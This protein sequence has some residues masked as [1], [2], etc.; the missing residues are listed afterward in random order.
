[1]ANPSQKSGKT[2]R[3]GL[4]NLLI[5]LYRHNTDKFSA[6]EL[7]NMRFFS[8]YGKLEEN[9][10]MGIEKKLIKKTMNNGNPLFEIKAK[11]N[12]LARQIYLNFY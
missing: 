12:E 6:T 10:N 5:F 1:M 2:L 8:S 3:K 4:L 11:A 7:N 9:L